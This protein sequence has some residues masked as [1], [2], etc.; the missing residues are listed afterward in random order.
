M[1]ERYSR[2]I[3]F[4]KIGVA[5]QRRISEAAVLIVGTGALGTVSSELLARAGVKKLILIDRDYVEASNLQRQTLF[6]EE[7]AA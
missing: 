5:G 3:L 4:N 1:M 2:Q 7:D 6:T